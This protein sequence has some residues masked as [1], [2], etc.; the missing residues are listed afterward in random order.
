MSPGAS[1]AVRQALVMVAHPDDAELAIGGTIAV[2]TDRGVEVT[3]AHFTNSETND[4]GRAERRAA[5][6]RAAAILGH[7]VLWVEDGRYN[8]VEEV[9]EFRWVTIV[10]QLMAER[11]PDLV[12]THCTDD[13]HTDHIRLAR[14]VIAS[15][16]RWPASLY[17]FAPN[18][19]RS[20]PFLRFEP[21]TFVDISHQLER[22][23][24]AI[25]CYNYDSKGFR[26]LNGEAIA[27]IA[28]YFG[29]LSGFPAA[30]ALRLERQRGLP[31]LSLGG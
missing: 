21:N 10:D 13:S 19:Y 20:Q 4:A 1:G 22:K 25:R 27:S 9:P 26:D 5:A 17:S 23:L 7:G 28:G 12:F 15:A 31:V 30:E 11:R 29:V 18:E 3:V 14:A 8:Q 6:H 24:A 16:R 2:L